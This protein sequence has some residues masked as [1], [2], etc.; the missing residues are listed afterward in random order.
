MLRPS[1][2]LALCNTL[3]QQIKRWP[4]RHKSQLKINL[5]FNFNLNKRTQ[6]PNANASAAAAAAAALKASTECCCCRYCCVDNFTCRSCHYSAACEFV[7][8]CDWVGAPVIGRSLFGR[9]LFACL[10]RCGRAS[11]CQC[12]GVC[13]GC[14]CMHIAHTGKL[15]HKWLNRTCSA[16]WKLLEIN[17]NPIRLKEKWLKREK[18]VFKGP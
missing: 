9:R 18:K 15:T 6:K 17:W 3:W 2:K 7:C 4:N 13:A 14:V 1:V 5:N 11:L 16:M 8:V 10:A 12:V